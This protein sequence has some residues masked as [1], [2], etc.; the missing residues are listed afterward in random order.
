MTVPTAAVESMNG[1]LL[2]CHLPAGVKG[3]WVNP[4][5]SIVLGTVAHHHADPSA[6]SIMRNGSKRWLPGHQCRALLARFPVLVTAAI[7]VLLMTQL[8]GCTQARPVLTDPPPKTSPLNFES[9]IPKTHFATPE[10]VEGFSQDVPLEYLIGPGDVLQISVWHRPELS[11]ENVVVGPD[12]RFAATRIGTLDVQGQTVGQV[13]EE[14][15]RRLSKLYESPEVTIAIKK[16]NNNKAFVLGRVSNPGVV[17]FPGRGT[18]LEALALAGG[19]PAHQ[20]GAILRKCSIIR[21]KDTVI[22][23]DLNELLHQGN[24]SLNAT[25]RNNDIVFIPEADDE[26]VYVMGEVV[27]PSPVPIRTRLTYLDAVMF[28]GGPT[29]EAN[30]EKTYLVRF[31][32]KEGSVQ[33]INLRQMIETGV[34]EQNFVLH[35]NDIIYVTRS[36]MGDFN[37]ALSQIQPALQV[38]TMGLVLSK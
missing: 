33:Q 19:L 23:I 29:K 6:A 34:F 2:C 26:L 18:L 17:H 9:E 5:Q 38:L 13:T 12:G 15:V 37:Y 28:S 16:F 36:G 35:P 1:R 22:W 20:L 25:I 24:M 27:K 11:D 4:G 3:E 14:V 21:G 8:F 32:G 31:D 10:K 30:L 7:A